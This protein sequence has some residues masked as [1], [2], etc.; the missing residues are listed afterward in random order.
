[1]PHDPA[2]GGMHLIVRFKAGVSDVKLAQLAQASGFSVEALSSCATMHGC[3][4]GLLLG[5]TNIAEADAAVSVGRSES[6]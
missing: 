3:G 1:M 4:R 5:F 6:F 2:P